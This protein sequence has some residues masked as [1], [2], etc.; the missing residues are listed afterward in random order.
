[1]ILQYLQKRI[2]LIQFWRKKVK[3]Q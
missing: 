2:S 1:M 3:T